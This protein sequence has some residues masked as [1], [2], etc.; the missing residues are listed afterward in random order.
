V[1]LLSKSREEITSDD[2]LTLVDSPYLS[3]QHSDQPP[4]P[5]REDEPCR[6]CGCCR[7]WESLYGVVSFCH[8]EPIP[9]RLVVKQLWTVRSDIGWLH[10]EP[11]SLWNPF[12]HLDER[13]RSLLPKPDPAE[14]F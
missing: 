1:K 14:I 10:W 4:P 13:A 6:E 9:V 12:E 11:S 2:S 8:C 5:D 3:E 7:F